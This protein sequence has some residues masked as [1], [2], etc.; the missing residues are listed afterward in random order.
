M[1]KQKT[2]T[3]CNYPKTIKNK[4]GRDIRVTIAGGKFRI[5]YYIG[6]N[7]KYIHRTTE[8]DCK[9]E[10]DRILESYK[11]GELFASKD[12]AKNLD[13]YRGLIV[14][15]KSLDHVIEFYNR[16]HDC[17]SINIDHA[18]E[19]FK[20]SRSGFSDGYINSIKCRLKAFRDSVKCRIVK[21]IDGDDIQYFV[22]KYDNITTKRNA[23]TVTKTFIDFCRD[24]GYIRETH[25]G[26]LPYDSVIL[27]T[28]SKQQMALRKEERGILTVDEFNR[29]FTEVDYD[30]RMFMILVGVMGFRTAEALRLTE[31]DL[32]MDIKEI[33]VKSAKTKTSV[34]KEVPMCWQFLEHFKPRGG[35]KPLVELSEYV[36]HKRKRK[37]FRGCNIDSKS[38]VLRNSFI[39]YDYR[40]TGSASETARKAGNSAKMVMGVYRKQVTAEDAKEWFDKAGFINNKQ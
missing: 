32:R 35:D 31:D 34:E 19:E 21:E 11:S 13:Y 28:E 5:R 9:D 15:G 20:A 10:C 7:V 24:N 23:Y 40:R 12:A 6:A 16:V 36:L 1:D 8:Q 33:W 3:N 2:V 14:D 25:G 26:K 4:W 27:P 22:D 37:A 29:V 30:V 38:N 18:I 39:S 17:P